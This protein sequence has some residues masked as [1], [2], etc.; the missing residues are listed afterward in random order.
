MKQNQRTR[1]TVYYHRYH[2]VWNKKAPVSG[3]HYSD[4][5][6]SSRTP[7]R[8]N[9]ARRVIRSRSRFDP[10]AIHREIGLNPLLKQELKCH[11]VFGHRG[12]FLGC[13]GLAINSLLETQLT[14]SRIDWDDKDAQQ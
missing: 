10:L 1:Y 2:W 7:A 11:S 5:G 14:L 6:I 9:A 12:A 4:N 3:T 8:A 13:L